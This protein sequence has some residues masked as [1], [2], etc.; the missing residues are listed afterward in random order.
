MNNDNYKKEYT[1]YLV[2]S[3]LDNANNKIASQALITIFAIYL[4]IPDFY[5]G[6]YVILDTIT[7]IIQ[8]FAA[9]LFSKIGQSKKIVLI[10]YSIYRLASVAFL[11]IPFISQD[12]NTRTILF[13]IPAIIYAITG[14]LGYITFVNWRMSLLE[15]KDRGKFSAIK[16]AYKNTII[17][18]FSFLMGILLDYFKS[19]SNEL[20]GFIILFSIVF[21][22]AFIDIIIRI[23]TYK[24]DI[25]QEKIN[26]KKSITMPIKDKSFRKI[27]L[28]CGVY[29]FSIG[30]GLMY[31]NVYMLR[32]LNIS[33]LYYFILNTVLYLSE[34][35]FGLYWSKKI[36]KRNWSRILIPMIVLYILSFGLLLT[37][38]S[39]LI[40]VL[41]II[42]IMI[43]CANSAYDLYDNIAIYE[44]S[45]EGYETSYVTFERFVEGIA[46][47]IIP[48]VTNIILISNNYIKWTFIIALISF[49][50][51]FFIIKNIHKN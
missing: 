15:K 36:V 19:N 22:I 42:H 17:V 23:N 38:S 48:I 26:L 35:I 12:I 14:E 29:R 31:L 9:P 10:N 25:K 43:G 49:I 2:S 3:I 1:K 39:I 6:L 40:Y 45:L 50:F 37:K 28:F 34:T 7:N 5:I 4:G 33:Y 44:H 8:I 24:P 27:L 30:I 11:F 51:I 47:S 46:T 41:P 32:Y 13:F 21:I 20:I 18:L 16:N